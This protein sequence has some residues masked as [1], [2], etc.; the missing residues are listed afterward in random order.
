MYKAETWS[1]LQPDN[2]SEQPRRLQC[3]RATAQLALT[4]GSSQALQQ[5]QGLPCLC[6]RLCPVV[7]DQRDL[8]H[9]LYPVSAGQ[10]KRGHC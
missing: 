10:D 1:S 9:L 4:R 8:R 7:N 3:I 6:E 5:V 2:T